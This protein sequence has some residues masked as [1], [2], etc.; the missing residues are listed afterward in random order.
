MVCT[1]YI[2]SFSI[3]RNFQIERD[4]YCLVR[5]KRELS[6]RTGSPHD[7]RNELFAM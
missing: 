2:C 6:V 1:V 5:R 4:V 7:K 3:L